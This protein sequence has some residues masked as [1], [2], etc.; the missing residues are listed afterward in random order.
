[1]RR[2]WNPL[3]NDDFI[4]IVGF[5]IAFTRWNHAWLYIF[6]TQTSHT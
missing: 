4:I 5:P 6:I 2:G 1:M 3:R